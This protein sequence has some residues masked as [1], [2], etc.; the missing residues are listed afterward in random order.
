MKI[1][2]YTKKESVVTNLRSAV[3]QLG[4]PRASKVIVAIVNAKE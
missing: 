1:A 2:K 4:T 3:E